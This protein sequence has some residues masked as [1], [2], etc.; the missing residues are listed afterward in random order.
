MRNDMGNE[1]VVCMARDRIYC[2]AREKAQLEARIAEIE[3]R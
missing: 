1:V 2:L 3:G